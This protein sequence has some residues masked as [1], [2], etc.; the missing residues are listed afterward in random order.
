MFKSGNEKQQ[1][2]FHEEYPEIV[3]WKVGQVVKLEL[4]SNDVRTRTAKIVD[5]DRNGTIVVKLLKYNSNYGDSTF[6][7]HYC[8]R[9]SPSKIR[10]AGE[11]T[12]IVYYS[13]L[14]Y[15]VK[16]IYNPNVSGKGD[17]QELLNSIRSVIDDNE[18]EWKKLES[19]SK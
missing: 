8:S 10:V 14:K 3:F 4:D 12:E 13:A 5:I 11:I 7:L 1:F 15:D 2:Q 16:S 6:D 19:S 18:S 17:Y 9:I